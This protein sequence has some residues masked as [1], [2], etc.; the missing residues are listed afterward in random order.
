MSRTAP[1]SDVIDDE[2]AVMDRLLDLKPQAK[3]LVTKGA[4]AG[5]TVTYCNHSEN[6][7]VV[8]LTLLNTEAKLK[9]PL[10]SVQNPTSGY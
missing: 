9:L 5:N 4:F 10:D 7:V 2:V 1:E 3:L 8:L 6:R